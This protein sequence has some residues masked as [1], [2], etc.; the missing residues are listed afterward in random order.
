MAVF[1]TR[2]GVWIRRFKYSGEID[3]DLDEPFR[4]VIHQDQESSSALPID[5]LLVPKRDSDVLIVSFQG[6][7]G[8]EQQPPRF[9]RFSS[10][11]QRPENLLFISDTTIAPEKGILL[12]WYFGSA[13]DDLQCRVAGFIQ[14]VAEQLGVRRIVVTGSSGGGFAALV[15][16]QKIP[17]SCCL[18]FDPQ[19]RPA[20]WGVQ[21]FPQLIYGDN[22]PWRDFEAEFPTRLSVVE[23]LRSHV[24]RERFQIVQNLGDKHHVEL[25]LPPLLRFLKISAT[26]GASVD[27]RTRIDFVHY[28]EGHVPPPYDLVAVWLDRLTVDE[29][30]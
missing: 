27:G 12:G 9:E 3:V 1:D 8:K 17:G 5:S 16:G 23:E 7:L 11:R 14:R 10:L 24:G 18:A 29:A 20:L 2:H 13:A 21:S 30:A 25:Q 6:A 19:I 28:G 4:Y 26:G 22:V 15:I